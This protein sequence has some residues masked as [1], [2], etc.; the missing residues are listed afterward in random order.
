MSSKRIL[1]AEDEPGYL[2]LLTI[3]LTNVGYEVIP[4]DNGSSAL[5]KAIELKPDLV[6]TDVRMPGLDG[7]HFAQA[8]ADEFGD[9]CPKIIIMTSRDTESAREKGAA[10]MS[11]ASDLVQKPFELP[12]LH[13][14]IKALLETGG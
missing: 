11:G 12:D 9:E 4:V 8:L 6:L 2:E 5:K 14:K 7:Y 3:S 1:I 13:A 10:M